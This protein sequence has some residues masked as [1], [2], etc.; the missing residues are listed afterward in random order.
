MKKPLKKLVL[1]RETLR[2]LESLRG[3]AGGAIQPAP[4]VTCFDCTRNG[5]ACVSGAPTCFTYTTCTTQG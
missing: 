2:D 3:V 1:N 5:G 4:T